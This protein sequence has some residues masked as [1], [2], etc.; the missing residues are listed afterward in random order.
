[1]GAWAWGISRVLDFLLTQPTVDAG[2]VA[3]SGV[4]RLGKAV[5]W[6]GAQ[7]ERFAAVIAMLSGEGGDAVSRRNFGESIADLVAP[8]RFPYWFAPR[9]AEYAQD[10]DSL[11]VDGHM[12]LALMAPRPLL[13]I[14]G[15][16][17]HWA[18]PKGEFLASLAAKP[19]YE[20]FGKRGVDWLEFPA[21]GSRSLNDMGYFIHKG[22][23]MTYLEDYAVLADFLDRH[24]RRAP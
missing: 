1:V 17:D 11:P 8:E 16:E 21:A 12:L 13:Q 20:L 10:V 19:V 9:Y 24:F 4:S 15:S 2:R 7:D 18:D 6:A 14:T 5:L 22:P 3:L 23:H